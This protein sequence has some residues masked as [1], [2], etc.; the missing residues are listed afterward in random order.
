MR[1]WGGI[2]EKGEEVGLD[3]K[4]DFMGLLCL[5]WLLFIYYLFYVLNCVWDYIYELYTELV[6]V[7]AYAETVCVGFRGVDL[8][9]GRGLREVESWV[10]KEGGEDLLDVD[11]GFGRRSGV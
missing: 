6:L 8:R 10:G 4:E 9:R 3:V 5:I 11:V 2:D 7:V 1:R